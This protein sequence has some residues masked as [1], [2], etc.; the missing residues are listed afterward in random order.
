[1]AKGGSGNGN[2]SGQVN[3]EIVV[4]E[5]SSSPYFLHNGD[6]P[7]LN[8]VSNLLTGANYH[9]WR[10]AMLMALTAKNKVG[11]VDGT[12]SRPMSHDL[13][14]GA[15]NRCNSMISS[16]IINAV[17][18][19]IA[20]SL[21]YLDSACDIWRDLNDRFNQ[22][23]H[24]GGLRVWTDYQHREYV[25]QFLMGLNDSY[26]QIRGQIL[27]M[28]PLPAINKVFSLVI[29][30]EHHRTVG[31]SYSG[32][33]N[34]D[35]ITFGS[36]SNAL[37][38]SS[39]GSKTRRD[40]I[41]CSYCGFQG[42]TKDKCYK[43]VGYPPG[44]KFKN[45]GP[46]SSSM[47]NNSEVLESLN[48]GSSESTISSLTT[49]QCQQLI[50]LLTNQ[51][52]ST[53]STSTENS[54]TGPLVSNFAVTLPTGITV[55][56]DRVGSVILSKDVK[57]LNVLFVPTFKYNLLSE[58]S[59]GKMIGK[60][61]RKGQLY[62]LDFD[63]FVADKAFVAASRIPTSNILLCVYLINRTP[64]P[65]LNNKTPFE[66]LHDKLPDYSHLRVFGCL[67]YVSTLKANRT[68]FSPRAKATVFL[69]YPFGF[70][71]YKLLDI[72]TRSIS[73]S[74]N[75][76]FHEEIFPFS[77]INPCSSPD[78]SSDLFHDRVLPCIAADNDQSSSVLPRVV[79][80]P[81]LQVAPSSRPTRVSKQP[82][83]LKDYQC[84]LINSVA[85]VETHSTS[86]P[87]QHF[88]SYDK[89]SPS[90]KLF[91]LSVSIISEPSSFAKAAEIPEWRAAMD[92][93]LEALEENKTWSIVS[94][95]VERYKARLV[96]KGY[97]Q[98]EGIDYVD[99]FSPV[100]KLVTVKLL[101]AI[102]AVKGWRLSQLDVNNAFLHGDLNEEVYMK[103]PPGYN[104]KGES[105]PSNA[106]CLLHKSLYGLKQASRQ[107]FSK[108]STAIMGLGFSQS[109]SDHSLFIKN[110]D[111]LFI[112]LLVYV[113]D[114][115]IA[116][117]NQGAIADLKSELNKLFSLKDLG[118]VKYFLGLEI[119]KSS[120][121]ICVSQQKYVLDLLSDFGYLG[122][123]AASTPMEANVKLSMDEGVD[124][125][126]VS[127]YRRL[128]GKLL[129]LTLTRPDISYAVGR[130]S[131]FISRP[132]LPHLHAAQR[133]LRYLKGNPGMGLFFP[134]NSEL[135][136]MAYTD[137]DWA[138]CPDSRIS[139]TGFC[140]FLGNSLVSWKSKKQHIVSRSLLNWYHAMANTSC[141][142]T[143][144]LAL[145]KT[146][147]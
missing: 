2:R 24:C 106:V 57:L 143:W 19:E 147:V 85:H 45:K 79:S 56:I 110:V 141:E 55:P 41:T 145:L 28:D 53:S 71:G 123:K 65:F 120:T 118:D 134:S 84:S 66:I 3:S 105:L 140:V 125:P 18:R 91:S 112:A 68:K 95:P 62:Q 37:A 128:L 73:I 25:L 58:P 17:S 64:S 49:M 109:P 39:G 26:A 132:K 74:R 22:V 36:N 6:H 21:L 102:A 104:R 13:I 44:W 54:S 87:I 114:V 126:D 122:C 67:C 131:Q 111:G 30:E 119:A 15:W 75:V 12:I 82:S 146:L 80:Q 129:Y 90:Y 133:I 92:C 96:A 46:N 76:I 47:A 38:G 34:S 43:L 130:L 77:K 33:H 139:I 117:N 8:L 69:G 1:M 14:Y 35:P 40:R 51:L 98:R 144:L 81:P 88:L 70:K 113:D 99:N 42:H 78:I 23:C 107:W 121:G 127:L 9:T 32:S 116:S 16:W 20:D 50:Q 31:Y 86:H 29:Q 108:F 11:F 59:R 100:A 135:R 137:S 93:E 136:L 60:G 142:I 94:L 97:T 103:L 52:S 138:R 83:Y 115:I 5:D 4:V 63:S 7:G 27:M 124:L 72:E 61:S 10:K 89:L 48:A 101:L